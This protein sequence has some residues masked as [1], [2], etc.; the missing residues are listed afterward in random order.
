MLRVFVTHNPEDLEAY[1]GRA[2][3]ELRTVADVVVNPLDHDLTTHELAEHSAGCQVVIAHRSTPGEALLFERNRDVVAFL[4]T[5]VDDLTGTF[6]IDDD[7]SREA[8]LPSTVTSGGG[9]SSRAT[10]RDDDGVCDSWSS[11]TVGTGRPSMIPVPG[12]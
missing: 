11:V 1:Y 10:R 7:D 6:P 2:L 4:R 3:P 12:A 5:A 9:F 8:D